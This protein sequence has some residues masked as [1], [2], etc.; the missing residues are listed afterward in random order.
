ML[1]GAWFALTGT[2][3]LMLIG[4]APATATALLTGLHDI[5][6]FLGTLVGIIGMII[7][8]PLTAFL[9]AVWVQAQASIA[10]GMVADED[11]SRIA[12][13]G[14][15][16]TEAPWVRHPTDPAPALE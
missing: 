14:G 5:V 11:I 6:P 1:A 7:A 10:R 9:V 3:V 4:V 15:S 12:I 8:V 16:P 2:A 13:P